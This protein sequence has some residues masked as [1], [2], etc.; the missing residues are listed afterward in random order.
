[1]S[2]IH[3]FIHLYFFTEFEIFF[4][5]YYILPYEKKLVYDMFSVNKLIARFDD[6]KVVT[7][8]NNFS[9]S[10]KNANANTNYDNNCDAAQERID[11]NN[12]KLWTYCF[13]YII[14]I[15]ALLF[16]LFL[17]DVFTNYKYFYENRQENVIKQNKDKMYNSNS[18]LTAFSSGNN[19]DLKYKKT[20]NVS[21]FEIEMIDIEI[22]NGSPVHFKNEKCKELS[23]NSFCL[24]YWNKSILLTAICNTTKFIIFIG[25]F[26]YLFFIFIINK[27]KIVNSDLLL[28]NML[29]ELN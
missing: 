17:F 19:L 12:N 8:F 27:F 7:L 23:Y 9:N 5:I 3:H 4:Y 20:D 1:M 15:N 11:N 2:Y 25:I 13:I 6:D 28:C 21:S 16:L 14:S 18:S 29:K 10:Y 22:N 24:Y 26:E